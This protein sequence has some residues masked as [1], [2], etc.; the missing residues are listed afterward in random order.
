MAE[1]NNLESEPTHAYPFLGGRRSNPPSPVP[2]DNDPGPTRVVNRPRNPAG[3]KPVAPTERLAAR[4]AAWPAHAGRY[5]ILGEIA[6][7]GMG[8]VLRGHDPELGRDLAIKLQLDRPDADFG[9]FLEEARI[10]GR[11]QHPGII[12]IHEVGRLS[13][14]TPFFTMK[15]VEGRTLSALLAERASPHD[16]LPRFLKVFEQVCQTMAYA[17]RGVIHRDLK[18]SNIMVGDFGEV[19]VMDWG[20][21]KQ[22]DEGG[23][24]KE[25]TEPIPAPDSS[26]LAPPS[27]TQAGTVVGTLAYMPPE[28]AR[29]GIGRAATSSPWG[30]F[31]ARFSP[32][33]PP[34]AAAPA[35]TSC[36]GR[37]PGNSCRRMNGW[38]KRRGC[39]TGAAGAGLSGAG[40][41]GSARACRRGR[42][43]RDR[44]PGRRAG[45]PSPGRDGAGRLR[46]ASGGGDRRRGAGWQA[47]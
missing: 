2:A 45:T 36:S 10:T 9:R 23:T 24:R 35:R 47:S 7:G 3:Q 18:P 8:V 15:L 16:D 32:A 20:L 14:G 43:G 42:R 17:M 33:C 11:L 39:G 12:P 29:R 44:L 27:L 13:D 22:R 41:Q 34:T 4:P 28:Q 31:S 25:E 1:P 40:P 5:R 37:R 19:Q 30:P 38:R 26:S 46:G 21:A 6:R